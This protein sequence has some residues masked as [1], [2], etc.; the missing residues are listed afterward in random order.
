VAGGDRRFPA[1]AVRAADLAAADLVTQP[2][3]SNLTAYEL[4]DSRGLIADVIEVEHADVGLT[5]VDASGCRKR[6][7]RDAQ[8]ARV[9][10]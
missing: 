6:L 1:M 3:D 2:P 8:I 10:L 5:A 4:V 7:E 9:G